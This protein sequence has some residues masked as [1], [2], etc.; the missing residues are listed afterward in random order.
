M[1]VEPVTTDKPATEGTQP[2][3]KFDASLIG[4]EVTGKAMLNLIEENKKK[5][6]EPKPEETEKS[7]IEGTPEATEPKADESEPKKKLS[8][9]EILASLKESGIDVDSLDTLKSKLN[10]QPLTEEQQK[11]AAK[12][13]EADL[14]KFWIENKGGSAEDLAEIQNLQSTED[15]QLV[16]NDF[17]NKLKS[18]NANIT[19][20][21][22]QA[23]FNK[24]F[25][26]NPDASTLEEGQSLPFDAEDIAA[27]Q[28]RIKDIA[29]RLKNNP[30]VI[31]YRN[32]EQEF[33]NNLEIQQKNNV[34]TD[35][36][37]TF[38]DNYKNEVEFD[39]NEDG[40]K[41]KI[42][43][44]AEDKKLLKTYLTDGGKKFT[45]LIA[46]IDE[47]GNPVTNPEK[48]VKNLLYILKGKE[49]IK[50]A[51]KE[52]ASRTIEKHNFSAKNPLQLENQPAKPAPTGKHVLTQAEREKIGTD[53]NM[54]T[55]NR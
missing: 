49:A 18:K 38:L 30:K 40:E 31:G 25:F 48:A 3:P 54:K 17:S 52:S 34:W 20:E 36:V 45:E 39:A 22:I 16:Y 53:V 9:E 13:Q 4:R 1:D 47:K 51:Y 35:K 42:T 5:L 44:T 15:N 6:T 55:F 28:E 50:N 26:I 11:R 24:Q 41:T 12:K 14:I 8:T 32:A 27:G 21:E 29:Q 19:P 23:R 2:K 33:K 46:D 7:K 10:N 43:L 37:S